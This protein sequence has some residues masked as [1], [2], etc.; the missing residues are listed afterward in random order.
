MS[1]F[2]CLVGLKLIFVFFE[3]IV[4]CPHVL[5]FRP[6]FGGY[7]ITVKVIYFGLLYGKQDRRMSRYD[8]LT[9][10]IPRG[11]TD[12]FCQIDLEFYGKTVFGFVQQINRILIDMFCEIPHGCF[13]VGVHIDVS[14]KAF[15]DKFGLCF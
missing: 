10:K 4:V 1:V 9:A 7:G 6:P 2:L 15:F 14:G 5:K 8:K 13:S 3:K 11:I 12:I